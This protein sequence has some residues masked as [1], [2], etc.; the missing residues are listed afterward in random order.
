MIWETIL[1]IIL[2]IVSLIALAA[3]EYI[4]HDCIPGKNCTH[5]IDPPNED[6]S[7][8]EYVDRL[9]EMIKNN[10][11]YVAWRMAFIAGIV[12]AILAIFFL[13]GRVPTLVELVVVAGIGFLVVYF[14]FS[15]IW[16]HFFYPNGQIIE[17]QLRILRDKIQTGDQEKGINTDVKFYNAFRNIDNNHNSEIPRSE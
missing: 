12:I 10:Y 11:E 17:D 16:A 2:I 13:K 15:W 6:A 9:T 4:S 5:K 7:K 1:V 14:A 8:L 3:S